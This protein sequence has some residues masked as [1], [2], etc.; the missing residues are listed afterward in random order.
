MKNTLKAK[1][2]TTVILLLSLCLQV[3][4]AHTDFPAKGKLRHAKQDSVMVSGAERPFLIST[5]AV[6]DKA[7]L[8]LL[9]HG[10]TQTAQDVWEQTSLP[11]LAREK[12]F[13]V[14]APQGNDKQWN[15]GRDITIS[16]V[17]SQSDD[18]AFLS[19]LI[20]HAVHQFKA[21]PDAVFMVGASNGGHM[22]MRFACEQAAMLKAA[23]NVISIMPV[24]L[25]KSCQPNKSLPWLSINGTADTIQPFEGSLKEPAM[26]SA[27]ETHQFWAKRDNSQQSR[28]IALQGAGHQ[29]ANPPESASRRFVVRLLGEP[30]REID[31]G[32][33]IWDFFAKTLTHPTTRH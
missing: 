2:F 32:Q 23:S 17:R 21:N 11:T 9:L 16:G 10:G 30:N 5:H 4:Q 18:V 15:D 14:I 24:Q 28:L 3:T 13:I 6:S 20:K 7:P 1:V 31:S 22:T 26:L 29:W 12:G 8:L 19:A 25:A 27:K 33:V